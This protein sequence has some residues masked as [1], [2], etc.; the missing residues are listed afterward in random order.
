[1]LESKGCDLLSPLTAY[2]NDV[3]AALTVLTSAY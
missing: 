1:M 2:S 3:V